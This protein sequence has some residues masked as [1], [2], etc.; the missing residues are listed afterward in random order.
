[1]VN[2]ILQ[3]VALCRTSELKVSTSEAL[4]CI[5]MLQLVNPTDESQFR[6]VLNTNFVKTRRD[7]SHFDQLYSLY[8]HNLKPDV[9]H[10]ENREPGSDLYQEV[11]EN[12]RDTETGNELEQAILEFL[13]GNPLLLLEKLQKLRASEQIPSQ[14]LK[15][16]LGGLSG[17]LE[18]MLQINQT[19]NRITRFMEGQGGAGRTGSR[20]QIMDNFN[21]RLDVGLN[22]LTEEN[23]P[24]NKG[25]KQVKSEVQQGKGIGEKFF[26]SLSKSEVEEMRQVIKQLV[27]KLNDIVT[28]RWAMKNRG[29]LDIKKTLRRAGR[30]HGIPIEVIYKKRPPRKGRIVTI[31]DIS[32]SVWSAARFMLNMLFSLQD[33]FA[34]VKSFVFISELAEVTSIFEKYDINE[35]VEKV[36]TEAGIQYEAL[37][38]YGETFVRFKKSHMDVLNKKTTL[39]I[40]GDGRSNHFNPQDQILGE[41]RDRCRRV[42][43]L[44]PE[45]E[46]FWNSGDSEM[47]LYK[48][49]CH[50]VRPCRNL[51]QLTEFIQELV[52]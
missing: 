9:G 27:R 17:R 50:E 16:N 20:K 26:S 38:D 47:N 29:V 48:A 7:Q 28:R 40:V 12:L 36:M 46:R 22:L 23:K 42:V 19:R 11:L 37:T 52:L 6:A 33:C 32:G 31:C 1:M 44:N 41:M 18:I 49:Y 15:S 35:A 30:Y 51:N 8:F 34:K 43:W 3:F 4:D 2:L 39:I 45:P 24:E 14:V 10:L 13:S 21:R 5:A 25:L